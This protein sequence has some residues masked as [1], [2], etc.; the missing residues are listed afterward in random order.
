WGCQF[1]RSRRVNTNGTV[2]HLPRVS[3]IVPFHNEGKL[4]NRALT[5]LAAQT[6]RGPI[7]IVIVDDAAKESPPIE[8]D[9]RHPLKIVRSPS[10]VYAG[11]ARNLGVKYSRGD[12]L[13][14]LDADDEFLPQRIERHVDFFL[15]QPALAMVGA[16]YHL[17]REK[18]CVQIPEPIE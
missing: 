3:V 16:A 6:Y 11:A 18:V 13:C 17:H 2:S 8:V 14:F 10:N 9:P 12:Y 1:P 5:S 4:I 15:E 7:E